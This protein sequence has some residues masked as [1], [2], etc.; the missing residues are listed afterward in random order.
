M[1]PLYPYKRESA[2]KS[3]TEFCKLAATK[4]GTDVIPFTPACERNEFRSTS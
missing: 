3:T 2:R 4:R 1:D